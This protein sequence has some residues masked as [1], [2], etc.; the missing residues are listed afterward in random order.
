MRLLSSREGVSDHDFSLLLDLSINSILPRLPTPLFTFTGALF[1]ASKSLE[2]RPI[3][4]R[5]ASNVVITILVF[6]I[7]S[8][9]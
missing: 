2:S 1:V 7:Y 4:N 5:P 6:A 8:Q 3:L 9:R